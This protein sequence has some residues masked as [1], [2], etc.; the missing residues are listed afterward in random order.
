MYKQLAFA[1]IAL[2]LTGLPGATESFAIQANPL[3]RTSHIFE[4]PA[5]DVGYF[6]WENAPLGVEHIAATQAPQLI[7][8]GNSSVNSAI[9]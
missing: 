2:G 7:S 1:I 6:P 3:T 9:S 8:T 4:Q 5:L